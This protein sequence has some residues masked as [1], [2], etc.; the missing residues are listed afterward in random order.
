M[1]SYVR[2]IMSAL[3]VQINPKCNT[4]LKM[5]ISHLHLSLQMQCGGSFHF[6]IFFGGGGVF[7]FSFYGL[8]FGW[9]IPE[10]HR[11][12][13]CSFVLTYH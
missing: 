2:I 9:T 4:G 5:M 3:L 12:N 6:Y 8:I 11:N 10:G 1:D 13:L 7:K